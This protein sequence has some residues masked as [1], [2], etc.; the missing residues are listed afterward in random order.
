MQPTLDDMKFIEKVLRQNDGFDELDMT[1]DVIIARASL[2]DI[3]NFIKQ[4]HSFSDAMRV[5]RITWL[6]TYFRI[7]MCI[8]HELEGDVKN[9]N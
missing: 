6:C 7:P 9:A 8:K 2:R 1:T 4:K 3:Y 5:A